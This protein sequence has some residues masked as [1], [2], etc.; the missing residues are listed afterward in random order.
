MRCLHFC[1]L[2]VVRDSGPGCDSGWLGG[3]RS[4][5]HVG[6]TREGVTVTLLLLR[7]LFRIKNTLECLLQVISRTWWL[8]CYSGRARP[9]PPA[10]GEVYPA[11]RR[12]RKCR[13][14]ISVP[15]GPPVVPRSCE[16][17]R[18]LSGTLRWQQPLRG[19]WDVC[20]MWP[21]SIRV[22]SPFAPHPSCGF[23]FSWHSQQ[24]IAAKTRC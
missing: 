10:V 22:G 19:Q 21:N 14:W 8:T 17:T 24:I 20:Q 5:S 23:L 13:A 11:A 1:F 9:P 12:T 7:F 3:L 4:G 15:C 16:V 6:R 2:I 18:A